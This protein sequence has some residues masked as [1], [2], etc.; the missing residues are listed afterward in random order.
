MQ[1]PNIVSKDIKNISNMIFEE[2]NLDKAYS[3]AEN[4]LLSSITIYI[5]IFRRPY[6]ENIIDAILKL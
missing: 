4:S 2:Y 3:Y 6:Y 1:L 5:E